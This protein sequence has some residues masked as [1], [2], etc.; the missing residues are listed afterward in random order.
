MILSKNIYATILAFYL[1]K[2]D[3][4]ALL[5]LGF[6]SHSEAFLKCAD[7]LDVKLN[8]IKLRRDE[9][10]PVYNWRRGWNNRPMAKIICRVID[11]FDQ[12]SE[13]D[14]R[15]LV[16]DMLKHSKT[17]NWDLIVYKLQDKTND[18]Q[19]VNYAT[20]VLT[21]KQAESYFIKYHAKTGLPISGVLEDCT[22][23]GCGYD[24]L[25]TNETESACIEVKGLSNYY[26][27]IL[28]TD[29]EWN[30]ALKYGNRYYLCIVRN[31]GTNP[32][33]QFIC[34]PYDLFHPIENIRTTI[35]VS[36]TIPDGE[37][38]KYK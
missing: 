11:M 12:W 38:L 32:D 33:I 16:I 4:E 29:K 22:A 1:A 36:Y 27:G 10:D 25:V 23:K 31:L 15:T 3:R 28:L 34:N 9:F 2:Y 7:I 14:I 35:Q 30:A 8:Y 37:L 20:R 19:C 18:I 21:G 24:F 13:P 17:K 5:H 6:S 26:G